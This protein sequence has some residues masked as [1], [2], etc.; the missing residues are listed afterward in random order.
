LFNDISEREFSL[1]DIMVKGWSVYC[2]QFKN[3][4]ILILITSLPI[5]IIISILPNDTSELNYI[6]IAM[7]IAGSSLSIIG[8]VGVIFL[9]E[10]AVKNN[11]TEISW[12]LA[13][14]KALTRFGSLAITSLLAGLIVIGLSLLLVIPGI[15]WFV[16]YTFFAQFVVLRGMRGKAALSSSKALVE[17]RWWK[18][19]SLNLITILISISLN[20]GNECLLLLLPKALNIITATCLDILGVGFSTVVMTVFFLNLDSIGVK[21]G[22][23]ENGVDE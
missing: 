15:I 3:L 21:D 13:I 14:S 10:S 2:Q 18:V 23:P 7:V 16:Y 8:Y 6:R 11:N 12:G 9:A 4:A 5:Y 1:S 20:W 19:F 17:G 22:K